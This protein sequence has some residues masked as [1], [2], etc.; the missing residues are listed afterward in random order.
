MK[1]LD[2]LDFFDKGASA[3]AFIATYD[4]EPQFFERRMLAKKTFAAADRIVIFM[5]IAVATKNCFGAVFLSQASTAATLSSRWNDR[6]GCFIPSF[7]LHLAISARTGSSAAIT[8]R[9]AVSRITW[10]SVRPSHIVPMALP[11]IT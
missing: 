7:T 11:V 4:F 6:R 1:P 3:Y 8:A 2:I 10:R 9:P 5:W